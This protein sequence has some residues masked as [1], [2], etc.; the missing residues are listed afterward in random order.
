MKKPRPSAAS[1]RTPSRCRGLR[2]ATQN[3]TTAAAR[4]AS[5]A[6]ARDSAKKRSDDARTR[7]ARSDIAPALGPP[8]ASWANARRAITAVPQSANAPVSASPMRAPHS[9][10]PNAAMPP[11]AIQYEKGGLWKWGMPFSRGVIQSPVA[12]ISRAISA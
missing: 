5:L 4:K 6:S 11:P 9:F 12:S 2:C 1:G 3:P 10:K 7:G 8:S